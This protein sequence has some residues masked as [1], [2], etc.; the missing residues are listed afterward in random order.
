MLHP[1]GSGGTHLN[2]DG[3]NGVGSASESKHKDLAFQ[4]GLFMGGEE[5]APYYLASGRS[6]PVRQSLQESSTSLTRYAPSKA[7]RGAFGGAQTV[8]NWRNPG[9]AAEWG[10]SSR[11]Q[12][13]RSCL[14]RRR[15]PGIAASHTRDERTA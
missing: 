10:G 5:G 11:Q 6:F 12:S 8:R 13:T 1:Q 15:P 9:Q 7:R 14:G 2:R 3:P 4:F